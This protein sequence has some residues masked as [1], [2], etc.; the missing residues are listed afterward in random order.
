MQ[1]SLEKSIHA[2]K[3]YVGK[4]VLI[5][6]HFDSIAEQLLA[7]DCINTVAYWR[8]VGHAAEIGRFQCLCNCAFPW[9][10]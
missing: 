2:N 9:Q 7:N 8:Y 5:N 10:W 6:V 4:G 3:A 1:V